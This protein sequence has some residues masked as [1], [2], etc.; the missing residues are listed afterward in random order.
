MPLWDRLKPQTLPVSLLGRSRLQPLIDANVVM[1]IQLNAGLLKPDPG[2]VGNA[3]AATRMS[4]PSIF[5]S[6][7]VVRTVTLTSFPDW[8]C[9]LR[10]SVVELQSLNMGEGSGGFEALKNDIFGTDLAAVFGRRSGTQAPCG[11]GPRR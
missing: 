3:P 9:T 7:E 10:G 11:P 1:T 2:G 4:L 5:C 8:P 6:P